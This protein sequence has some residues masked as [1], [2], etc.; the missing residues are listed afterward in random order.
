MAIKLDTEKK[1]F[2]GPTVVRA[3]TTFDVIRQI[4]RDLDKGEGV[5]FAD[6]SE[7]MLS[8]YTPAKSNN[9]NESFVKSY[10]RDAVNKFGH[11]S[12]E[13]LGL[14]YAATA[15]AEKKEPAAP[16][17]K[18]STKADQARTDL[19]SAVAKLGEVTDVSE[20]ADSKVTIADLITET[21]RKQKTLEKDLDILSKDGLVTL[22]KIEESVYVFLTEAGF[23]KLDRSETSEA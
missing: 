2:M 1:L 15:A 6:L 20:I 18:K 21:K 4:V 10:V 3:G 12:H 14:E 19:L 11:L 8:E 22:E 13:D 5:S 9:Y 7:K 17:I 23:D 16:K